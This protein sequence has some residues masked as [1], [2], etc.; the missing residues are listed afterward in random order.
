[1]L[2]CS[3]CG[4]LCGKGELT[5]TDLCKLC[6]DDADA[7]HAMSEDLAR[8]HIHEI[9]NW[10][11]SPNTLECEVVEMGP[12][13]NATCKTCGCLWHWGLDVIVNK[14]PPYHDGCDCYT[15]NENREMDAE[16]KNRILRE[17]AGE[18]LDYTND[19]D[20]FCPFCGD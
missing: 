19:L 5:E 10:I 20:G 18:L 17:L 6:K 3:R 15:K 14:R 9:V 11:M 2:K 4:R 13:C 16:T 8:S 12:K 7:T 1:M